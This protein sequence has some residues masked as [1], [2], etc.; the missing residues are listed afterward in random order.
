MVSVVC[1]LP[2]YIGELLELIILK[3]LKCFPSACADVKK[4]LFYTATYIYTYRATLV[5]LSGV[6]DTV[7]IPFPR[8]GTCQ[9][10]G[11]LQ[12]ITPVVVCVT[13]HA[14]CHIL[15]LHLLPPL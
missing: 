6:L 4:C 8:P 5:A 15:L 10:V 1:K 12:F 2:L 7:G 13:Q 11:W 9:V 14:L 3:S